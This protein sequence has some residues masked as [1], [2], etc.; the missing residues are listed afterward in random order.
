MLDGSV[1]TVLVDDSQVIA[2]LMVVVCT[3]I[4]IN[5]Y[6]ILDIMDVK[7]DQFYTFR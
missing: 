6:S 7:N 5:L 3:K 4:G 2:N 1:K